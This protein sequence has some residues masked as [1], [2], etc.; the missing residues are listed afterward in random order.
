MELAKDVTDVAF[1]GLFADD[2]LLGD[3][4]I[5]ETLRDELQNFELALAQIGEGV[6]SVATRAV[7]LL[8]DPRRYP[9]VE[10]GFATSGFSNRVGQIAWTYLL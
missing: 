9:R 5:A 3:L 2:K 8:N 1:H 7:Q 4:G 6:W 10:D